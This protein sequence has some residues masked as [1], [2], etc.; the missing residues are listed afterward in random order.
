MT[1]RRIVSAIQVAA[2]GYTIVT[3]AMLWAP[4]P[5]L[6]GSEGLGAAVFAASCASCHGADGGGSVGP[7]L[8]S[9]HVFERFDSR[10]EMMAFVSSGTGLMPPMGERLGVGEIGAVTDFV[11]N[12]LSR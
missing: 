3:L 8:T 9:G 2:L 4:P 6:P 5:D 1:F 11:R 12:E 7:D 10:A